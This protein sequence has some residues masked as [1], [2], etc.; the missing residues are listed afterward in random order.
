MNR[1]SKEKSQYLR[2][3]ADNPIDWY[4]WGEEA[5]EKARSEDKPIMLSI[6][7]YSCHWCHVMNREVFMDPDV[8]S[9]L[10]RHYVCIK[11]DREERPDIDSIYMKYAIAIMGSGG[12]PLNLVLTHDLKPYYAFTYLSKKDFLEVM[13]KLYEI[14]ISNRDELNRYSQEVYRVVM[15]LSRPPTIKK[16]TMVNRLMD[17]VAYRLID[18][19]DAIYGGFGTRPKFPLYHNLR[20]LMK[21]WYYRRDEKPL[22]MALE[23]LLKI[24]FSSL[25]DHIG[26]GVHRY[27][28]NRDWSPPHFE[29][30]LYDQAWLIE[31]S[32][33]AY[34]ITG[35]DVFRQ[36]ILSTYRFLEREM[37]GRD[38]LYY[39]SLSAESEDGE[40][41]LY[42]WTLDEIGEAADIEVLNSVYSFN[43][44]NYIDEFGKPHDDIVIFHIDISSYGYSRLI[45]FY[46]DTYK[47]IEQ[48][49]IPRLLEHRIRNKKHM[50]PD[51]KILVDWNSMII[52]SFS[53]ASNVTGLDNIME[54]AVNA[55]RNIIGI[56]KGLDILPHTVIDGEPTSPAIFDDYAYLIRA[57]IDL[58]EETFESEY[59]SNAVELTE[60]A[61]SRFYDDSIHVL[62][63]N[64]GER[65]IDM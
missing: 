25:Y 12:W 30:M 27:A 57:S 17:I 48:E 50:P 65:L 24:R 9:Y 64:E 4:P 34:K 38:G 40:G 21:Y 11:V 37:K 44:G 8:A 32:I 22:N 59:V 20:F 49:Y 3:H 43:R 15:D 26:G 47:M 18:R 58:Y 1:L 41:S 35:E 46:R 31:A 63:F 51:K 19:Y 45:E 39:S 61:L 10:N 36:M 54:S 42:L 7:Y 53:K 33:D 2:L 62:Y 28:V 5:F 56:W 60:E 55:Y 14:W 29:K 52:S 6:G 16:K 23:T 13:E